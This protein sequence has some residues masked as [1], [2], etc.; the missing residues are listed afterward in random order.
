MREQGSAKKFI[1]IYV[2]FFSFSLF[3]LRFHIFPHLTRIPV[4]VPHNFP[5]VFFKKWFKVDNFCKINFNA[6]AMQLNSRYNELSRY[7]QSKRASTLRRENASKRER[8]RE[9]KAAKNIVKYE[10]IRCNRSSDEANH[11]IHETQKRNEDWSKERKCALAS[12]FIC[13][14]VVV[15]LWIWYDRWFKWRYEWVHI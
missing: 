9:K 6:I 10:Y 14:F 5:C 3:L 4:S 13:K 7:K 1:E 8:Q 11:S 12:V 2:R 15:W